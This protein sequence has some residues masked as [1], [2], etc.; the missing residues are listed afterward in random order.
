[1]KL[2]QFLYAIVV[3]IIVL[4]MVE[5]KK[6]SR[7]KDT[8][9]SKEDLTLFDTAN[10]DQVLKKEEKEREQNEENKE[11]NGKS[12][13]KREEKILERRER[14]MIHSKGNGLYILIFGFLSVFSKDINLKTDI[15]I[16]KEITS[17][18]GCSEKS[19]LHYYDQGSK[20]YS[21]F[22]KKYT[23]TIEQE[24]KGR[25][26]EKDASVIIGECLDLREKKKQEL[27]DKQ[28]KQKETNKQIAKQSKEL[29][30]K[31]K[32]LKKKYKELGNLIKIQKKLKKK[33]FNFKKVS[34]SDITKYDE[35]I[36]Q[37]KSEI[38]KLKESIEEL[39]GPV[40]EQIKLEVEIDS[41]QDEVKINCIKF[42]YNPEE[43]YSY[44]FLQRIIHFPKFIKKV[45]DCALQCPRIEESVTQIKNLSAGLLEGG[46]NL[47]KALIKKE[48]Q[49]L[50]KIAIKGSIKAIYYISQLFINLG[51]AAY[52]RTTKGLGYHLFFIG[53]A[54]GYGYRF[55]NILADEISNSSNSSNSE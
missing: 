41:L 46:K 49:N 31:T 1:M 8:P 34:D 42:A 54:F 33:I 23:N 21:E 20:D 28:E 22:I 17:H 39:E 37:L 35:E 24:I 38:E 29:N 14:A 43:S 19:L 32:E 13:S 45:I 26:N 44:S 7:N 55:L 15:A 36:R 40:E 47:I 4:Q 52:Y 5:A 48:F 30:K 3:T 25:I 11:D 50:I 53:R 9:T 16:Y 10:I 27:A 2:I 18:E 12:I 51:R 6:K